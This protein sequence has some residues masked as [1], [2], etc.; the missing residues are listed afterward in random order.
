M[1]LS[2]ESACSL[3]NIGTVRQEQYD[4]C[5]AYS[6]YRKDV[7]FIAPTGFGKSLVYQVAPLISKNYNNQVYILC[8]TG[9]IKVSLLWYMYYVIESAPSWH[10]YD[11][12]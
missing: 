9:L 11:Y 4:V 10:H 6:H 2:I 7:I 1:N 3:L 5:L 8:L 12:N